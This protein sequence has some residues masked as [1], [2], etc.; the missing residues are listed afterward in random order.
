[1]AL[2]T[3]GCGLQRRAYSVEPNVGAAV[4]T[5]PRPFALD[6][7]AAAGAVIGGDRKPP[8]AGGL[9]LEVGGDPDFEALEADARKE[10]HWGARLAVGGSTAIF[11]DTPSVIPIEAP[12]RG[13][14]GVPAD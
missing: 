11:A 13:T 8:S 4:D 9:E 6:S 2:I 1:M 10:P 3:S 7:G 14:E 12:A 5:K